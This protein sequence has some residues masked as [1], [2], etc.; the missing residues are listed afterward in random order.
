MG[1]YQSLADVLGVEDPLTREAPV[2][3]IHPEKLTAKEF[4]RRILHSKEYR[5]SIIRRIYAD[6]LP[7]AIEC[8][9]YDYAFGRPVE[10]VE[11]ADTTQKFTEYTIE[12]LEERA[13]N[14]AQ[15]AREM[16]RGQTLL[17]PTSDDETVN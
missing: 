4:S 9:L 1:K 17:D 11:V 15:L 16:R 8:R 12:Q 6:E 5:D 7:P 13:L 14:L 10:K 3:D 2:V